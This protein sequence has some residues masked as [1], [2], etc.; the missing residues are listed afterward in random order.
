MQKKTK[1]RSSDIQTSMDFD[2][3]LYTRIYTQTYLY[4]RRNVNIPSKYMHIQL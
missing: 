3:S 4:K 1:K 2:G